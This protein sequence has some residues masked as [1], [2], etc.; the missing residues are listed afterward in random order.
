LVLCSFRYYA[1]R[2]TALVTA[3]AVDLAK[4]WPYLSVKVKG[5]IRREL[6]QLF[7]SDDRAREAGTAGVKP[8]GDDC[9]RAAWRLVKAQYLKED[10]DARV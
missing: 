7:E 2:R 4:A 3:F 5:M 10:V 9:D 8:L 6:D 1:G